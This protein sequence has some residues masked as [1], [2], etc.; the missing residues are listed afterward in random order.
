[1]PHPPPNFPPPPSQPERKQDKLPTELVISNVPYNNKENTSDIIKAILKTQERTI[2]DEEFKCFRALSKTK[3]NIDND[4]PPR[5]IIQLNK[6]EDKKRF[7]LQNRINLNDIKGTIFEFKE[8]DKLRPI[9]I[10]ETLTKEQSNI[11]YLT[12]QFKKQYKYRFAWTRDGS[13]YLRQDTGATVHTI[14]SPEDL[15]AIKKNEQQQ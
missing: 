7:K 4:K 12:R 14:R 15:E 1:M 5:I 11:F 2:T 6:H 3:E 8:T 9:Y 10:N 13:T